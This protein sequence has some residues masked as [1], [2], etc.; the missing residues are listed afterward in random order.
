[1]KNEEG[2][3]LY[4]CKLRLAKKISVP[5]MNILKTTAINSI[6]CVGEMV[7]V[8]EKYRLAGIAKNMNMNAW[9]L[10]GFCISFGN[11]SQKFWRNHHSVW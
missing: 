4:T 2:V 1:M 8:S 7:I 6:P 9:M 11:Q 10:K 3:Y 5:P